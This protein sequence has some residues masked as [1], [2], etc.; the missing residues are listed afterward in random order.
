MP[1]A[2]RE[3]KMNIWMK[4]WTF[5]VTTAAILLMGFSTA[6]TQEVPER[7]RVGIQLLTATDIIAKQ[8]G[9]AEELLGVPVEWVTFDSGRDAVLALGAGGV[10][11]SLVGS[12]PAAFG[13]SSGVDAEVAWIFNL[14]GENEALVVRPDSGISTLE[15][16]ASKTL[17]VPFGSTTHYDMLQA[18]DTVGLSE[19]DVT[20]LDMDPNT[21]VAAFERGDIDGGWVWFPALEG[22]FNAGGTKIFDALDMANAG[23]PT[24]DLLLVNREF[25][26]SYP[27]TVA[28]YV[29]TLNRG[30]LLDRDDPDAAAQTMVDEF[31]IDL[32]TAQTAMTQ[33]RRLAAREQLDP[34]YLGTSEDVGAMADALMNQAQFLR[35]QGIISESYDL[36]FYRERVNP[37]YVEMSLEEGYTE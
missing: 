36:D 27:D 17:A 35:D 18:L 26:A 30:V 13:M 32:E 37:R 31:G 2:L 1:T 15:D 19:Q 16:L 21:M 6:S 10:D 28:R 11:M 20:L 7:V 5:L 29:A 23:F 3:T 34:T 12:A 4:R 14:L 9:W 25:G 33:V 8:R 22:L 24:A